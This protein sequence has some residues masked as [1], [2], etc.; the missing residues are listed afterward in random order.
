[1]NQQTREPMTTAQKATMGLCTQE[2]AQILL[3]RL[4]LIR[5]GLVIDAVT[6][7]ALMQELETL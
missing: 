3:D 5:G 7:K 4:Q 2:I 6:I 1:M